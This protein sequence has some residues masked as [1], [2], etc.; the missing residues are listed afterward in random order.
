MPHI[1]QKCGAS[2]NRPS[3]LI[4]HQRIHT[5]ERPFKC[6]CGRSYIR[7]Q[8]L[9]R[10]SIKCSGQPS[11][12]RKPK[13][14]LN[15][16]NNLNEYFCPKCNAGPFS[17]KK[18]V[19]AHIAIVHGE[20]RFKC[21]KCEAA[22]PTQSKLDRHLNRHHNL[23]CPKCA[24]ALSD[25]DFVPLGPL[26]NP[27]Q[28]FEDFS[29]LR[30][31]MAEAHPKQKFTCKKC[32]AQFS[33]LSQLQAHETTHLPLK[34]R[35]VFIC[36]HCSGSN[37]TGT[38]EETGEADIDVPKPVAFASKRSLQAHIR[39]VH[40]IK[41]RRF[42]CTYINCPAILSTK[43]KLQAHLSRH[44]EAASNLEVIRVFQ[45]PSLHP[46][47][48]RFSSPLDHEAQSSPKRR[49]KCVP[50]RDMREAWETDSQSSI[51]AALNR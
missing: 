21:G 31:H 2:F 16:S 28:R 15:K 13:S 50:L 10:H 47:W 45:R 7:Q 22:F 5:G 1:C 46:R 34:E 6:P 42:P 25:P 41:L 40:A 30:L 35:K 51:L 33:R 44:K 37:V 9:K 12:Y 39:A 24:M 32:E 3:R 20:R 11:E 4:V 18:S 29:E 8:H 38:N 14:L 43:Q 23:Q 49:R 36:P 19:W 48:T 26:F 27:N 17:K